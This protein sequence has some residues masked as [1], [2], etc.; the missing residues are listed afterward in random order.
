MCWTETPGPLQKYTMRYLYTQCTIYTHGIGWSARWVYLR[1]R[2]RTKT[3]KAPRR[4]NRLTAGSD[5]HLDIDASTYMTHHDQPVTSM[6]SSLSKSRSRIASQSPKGFPRI[7]PTR[8]QRRVTYRL[9]YAMDMVD[10]INE[11]RGEHSI[12]PRRR[13]AKRDIDPVDTCGD[14]IDGWKQ[15]F[16]MCNN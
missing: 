7:V 16:S 3:P 5:D 11:E 15:E 1:Q 6:T 4:L 8:E 13:Q 2:L 9:E 12:S 14:W 10:K